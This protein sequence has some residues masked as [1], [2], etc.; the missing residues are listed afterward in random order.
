LLHDISK[1]AKK[2]MN[3]GNCQAVEDLLQV[4]LESGEE[5]S[6]FEKNSLENGKG[7][8]PFDKPCKGLPFVA[9]G[10]Q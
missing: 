7:S 1:N 5:F 2:E 6:T 10:S 3:R 4:F 9:E 8:E